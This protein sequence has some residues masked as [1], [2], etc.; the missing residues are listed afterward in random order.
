MRP[1]AA[2][3][4]RRASG[5]F[6]LKG[7]KF[8]DLRRLRRSISSV[9]RD[10]GSV[11]ETANRSVTSFGT[12]AP[13]ASSCFSDGAIRFRDQRVDLV[14]GIEERLDLRVRG[15][16]PLEAVGD[17]VG[18]ARPFS[19]AKSSHSWPSAASTSAHRCAVTPVGE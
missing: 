1:D 13:A 14:D 3:C 2:P 15:I 9:V 6:A 7:S 17:F 4:R 19:S 18:V 5:Q 11:A 10:S 8:G 12:A 16:D